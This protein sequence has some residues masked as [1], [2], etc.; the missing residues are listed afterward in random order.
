[1]AGQMAKR[2]VFFNTCLI[3][4]PQSLTLRSIWRL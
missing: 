2:A 3:Q 1:M 4:F